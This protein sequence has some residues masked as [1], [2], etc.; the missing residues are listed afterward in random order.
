MKLN[1]KKV[2]KAAEKM[3]WGQV[4][5]NGGPPCF[6]VMKDGRFCGR[7]ERWFGHD[8]KECPKAGHSFISLAE[9]MSAAFAAPPERTTT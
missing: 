8:I 1:A 5:C 2:I 7:A 6:A 4:V 3:A 9:I